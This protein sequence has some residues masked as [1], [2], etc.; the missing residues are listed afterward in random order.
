MYK[1]D[2]TRI[3]SVRGFRQLKPTNSIIGTKD[4]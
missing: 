3:T 1:I 2:T 4:T